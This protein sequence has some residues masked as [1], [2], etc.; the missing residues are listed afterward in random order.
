MVRAGY[1]LHG[2]GRQPGKTTDQGLVFRPVLP[3]FRTQKKELGDAQRLDA[4][5]GLCGVANPSPPIRQR[6]TP[7]PG[8]GCEIAPIH[9]DKSLVQGCSLIAQAGRH[10]FQL[11]S[12]FC[13]LRDFSLLFHPFLPMFQGVNE[14]P[15][16]AS[17]NG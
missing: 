7:N 5:L 12:S 17:G 8:I 4:A 9:R 10:R 6:R 14:H 13:V 16:D 15:V 3:V 2:S 1:L 11:C